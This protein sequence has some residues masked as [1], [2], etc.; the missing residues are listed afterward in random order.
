MKR[1]LTILAFLLLPL[2][3]WAMTPVS[4]ADL[5]N[6]TGQA[7]VNINADVTMDIG[8]GTMA[9]GDADGIAGVYNPWGT[10][11][12]TP[13][14]S[15]GGY[16]GIKGFNITN[17]RIKARTE[18]TDEWN[19]YST[20]ILKPITIDVATGTKLDVAD[21]TFVRFGLGALQISMDAMDFTVALGTRTQIDLA[22]PEDNLPQEMGVVSLGAMSVYIN[23]YSYVDIFAHEGQGV[24]FE[25]NVTLDRI[26]L[27]YV[28]W[29]DTDGYPA[30]NPIYQQTGYYW[31]DSSNTAGYIGLANLNLGDEN[32]PA[33]T[34]N[35]TVQID[36]LT[37][38]EG[39]YAMLPGVADALLNGY[40][41]IV[42]FDT[43]DYALLTSA[44][45]WKDA[46]YEGATA[47]ITADAT[48][49]GETAATAWI[50]ANAVDPLNPTPAELASAQAAGAAAAAAFLASVDTSAYI[51]AEVTA[52]ATANPTEYA[53]IMN[54]LH[55]LQILQIAA[56]GTLDVPTS[57]VHISFP[58]NF[59]VVVDTIRADV[60][61]SSVAD[62]GVVTA[63]PASADT[64]G[65]IYIQG[66]DLTIKQNSWVDIWAH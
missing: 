35:G 9:W 23:P 30:G 18:A 32:N 51:S 54:G 29:G 7:G 53:N 48:A 47:A 24:D 65:D 41:T 17:L 56:A 60:V 38:A 55:M 52:L 28:S 4:D 8:I 46:I 12:S 62:L 27:G 31:F 26:S 15:G 39:V 3:V 58:T 45:V 63:S 10:N 6:V 19:G 25:V 11:A 64:L 42:G 57:I 16:V 50:V 2:S 14:L 59:Q 66:I 44:I 33:V 21:T 61:L 37:T 43:T 20:L 5:S 13:V 1:V 22:D 36:V 34:V 40:G 49:A